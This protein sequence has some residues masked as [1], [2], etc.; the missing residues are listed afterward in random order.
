MTE[1]YVV[2]LVSQL[3]APTKTAR[4]DVTPGKIF[5][6][7]VHFHYNNHQFF[8][9][10]WSFHGRFTIVCSVDLVMKMHES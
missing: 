5:A 3:L 8:Q 7:N 1:D 9:S 6:L 4:T 2:K 10:L